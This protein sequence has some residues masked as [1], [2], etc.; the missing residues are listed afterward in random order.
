M[1]GMPKVGRKISLLLF[2]LAHLTGPLYAGIWR[3]AVIDG[4]TIAIG[5]RRIRYI[6]IDA[7]EWDE[8]FFEEAK[9]RNKELLRGK[10]I[11]IETCKEEPY[12]R[13]GRTLAWVYADGNLV[14]AQLLREGLAMALI[15]PPCGKRLEKMLLRLQ[16]EARAKGLGL[17]SI[18]RE[19][20]PSGEAHRHI[21]EY[22][23]VKGRVLST[24]NSGRAVFLN[25]GLDYR[26]DFTVVIPARY[27]K[28]FHRRGIVPERYYKG[29]EVLVMGRIGEYNGPEIVVNNPSQ[30]W[31]GE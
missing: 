4:D 22:R 16:R 25:F 24:Y 18:V 30:I 7:P 3:V 19:A 20:I 31:I 29:K 17:W 10:R 28:D 15:I 8:P 9:R 27:L 5:N 26:R 11:R 21:G 6:G 14:N 23:V 12:D 1:A 13:Y 2:L